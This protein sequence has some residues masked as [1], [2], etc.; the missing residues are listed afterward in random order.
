[1]HNSKTFRD[2]PT[3]DTNRKHRED[4]RL[5]TTQYTQSNN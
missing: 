3:E 2:R 4:T 1:M 5:N